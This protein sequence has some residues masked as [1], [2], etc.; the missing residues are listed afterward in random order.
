MLEENHDLAHE[1]PEYK[2]A[3]HNLKMSDNHFKKLF[4]EYDD[5]NK[6]V[7]RIEKGVEAAS[8]ERL[9]EL[10]KQRLALKDEMLEMLQS[11]AA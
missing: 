10:K 6:E 3:I 8:D 5:V 4:G 1:L 9:E 2:E 7:L 11:A